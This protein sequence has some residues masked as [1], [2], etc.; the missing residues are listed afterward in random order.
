MNALLNY[1]VQT[2]SLY[3][4]Q[5][6][7][8]HLISRTPMGLRETRVMSVLASCVDCTQTWLFDARQVDELTE[9]GHVERRNP[10]LGQKK[11]TT[12]AAP[13]PVIVPD[14]GVPAPPTAPP[15]IQPEQFQALDAPANKA[16]KKPLP[17]SSPPPA[18]KPP[19]VAPPTPR[20]HFNLTHLRPFLP[21]ELTRFAQQ[22]LRAALSAAVGAKHIA[23]VSASTQDAVI[24]RLC[25]Q[26]VVNK[27]IV[28]VQQDG[29]VH[30]QW[31]VASKK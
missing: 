15:L 5:I 4:G 31:V 14:A 30:Y 13:A 21:A 24:R 7:D 29:P 6:S 19:L 17:V 23:P 28:R 3:Q 10:I 9:L 25:L 8:G 22:D 1:S 12:P 20:Q 11:R 18:E 26:G 2:H 27:L 16:A